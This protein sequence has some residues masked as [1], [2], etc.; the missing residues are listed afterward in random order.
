[1][2][3]ISD[4]FWQIR[5]YESAA[6]LMDITKTCRGVTEV[7]NALKQSVSRVRQPIAWSLVV[8]L[9]PH[10]NFHSDFLKIFLKLVVH[11]THHHTPPGCNL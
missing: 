5:E 2:C 7:S 3:Q 6:Q 1:M 4:Y 11:T 8:A 9:A 10:V